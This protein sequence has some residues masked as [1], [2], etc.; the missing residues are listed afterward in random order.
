MPLQN[1]IIRSEEIIELIS[2]KPGWLIRRG[3]SVFFLVLLACGAGTYFIQYPDVVKADATVVPVNAPKPVVAKTTGRL[4]KLFKTDGA[5]CI[6]GDIIAFLEST[7]KHEEVIQLSHLVD[8]L[9]LLT[10]SNR[11][12][13]IPILFLK[14]QNGFTQLGELQTNYRSFAESFLNFTNYLNTGYYVK[15]KLMLQKDLFNTKR[16]YSNLLSQKSLQQ[17]DLSLIQQTHD[18]QQL[19]KDD[20]VIS[21]Y[22][23]RNEES[24]LIGKKMSI[25][26]VNASLISNENQQNALLKEMMD[27]DNQIVQQ[28]KIFVQA[29]NSFKSNVEEW[30]AKY[31]LTAPVDGTVSLAGFLQENQQVDIGKTVCFIIPA[32]TQ[33]FCEVLL[34]QTNFGKVK[35]GQD[36][37]LKF[38]S[39][40]YQEFGSVKG[41][42]DIIKNIPTDSGYLSKVIM[43]QGLLTNY[44]KQLVFTNGMKAQAE[45]ITEN[46]RLSDRLLNGLKKIIKNN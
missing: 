17:K 26:Q 15:R 8:S 28:K 18:A 42:M 34:P 27:L 9:Q 21:D 2:N 37:L 46:M 1:D 19:L 38:Q 32:N 23:M 11:I 24:K 3:V 22:D 40:P 20:K 45:I 4:I 25:P 5:N 30:K 44:N 7:A 39:Y 6:A 13:E 31:I 10:D 35:T 41:R 43:P 29:L 16:L 12:E 33:Y 36:V 14:N